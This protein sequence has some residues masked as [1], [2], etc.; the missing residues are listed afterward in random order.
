MTELCNKVFRTFGIPKV[1][2]ADRD[3]RFESKEWTDFC[4]NHNIDLCLSS[5]NHPQTDGQSERAIKVMKEKLR[6]I[7][8]KE[9]LEQVIKVEFSINKTKSQT[10]GLTPFEIVLGYIPELV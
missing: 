3:T 8:K 5:P 6:L 9:W 4:K 10:T 2:V 7:G 1:I